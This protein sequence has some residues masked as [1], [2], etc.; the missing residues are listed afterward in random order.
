MMSA[1]CKTGAGMSGTDSGV[2]ASAHEPSVAMAVTEFCLVCTR[3]E[4]IIR[5]SAAEHAVTT[6]MAGPRLTVFSVMETS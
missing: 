6:H 5:L 1:G 2:V 3:R 4:H